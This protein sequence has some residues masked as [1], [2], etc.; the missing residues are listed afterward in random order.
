M[1]PKDKTKL[2]KLEFTVTGLIAKYRESN[3]PITN[4]LREILKLIDEVKE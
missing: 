3:K 1:E 2:T 4:R